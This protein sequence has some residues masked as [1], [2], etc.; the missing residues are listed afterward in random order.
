MKTINN[1]VFDKKV[2]SEYLLFALKFAIAQNITL[3]SP[4]GL[5]YIIN[6]TNI[7]KAWRSKQARAEEAKMK[8]EIKKLQIKAEVNFSFKNQKK[9]GFDSIF[10]GGCL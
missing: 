2:D 10:G 3:N 4:F 9:D 8:E 5:H 6:N 1:I 7:Q